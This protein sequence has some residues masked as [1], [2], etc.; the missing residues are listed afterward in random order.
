MAYTGVQNKVFG[1]P[2]THEYQVAAAVTPA[3]LLEVTS[4]GK[5]QH[6]STAG[7][8][9]V[10][11]IVALEN[12]LVGDT[13]SDASGAS[14]FIPV[15]CPRRGDIAIMAI[16]ASENIAVGDLLESAGDGTL[17]ERVSDTSAA[18]IALSSIVGKALDAT[19]TASIVNIRVLI[20]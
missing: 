5:V 4:A 12:Q 14:D 11:I 13:I 9:V 18:T 10:P 2:A 16:K 17:R 6:H 8:M 19:N 1:D 3:Y 7:G 15:W 20:V